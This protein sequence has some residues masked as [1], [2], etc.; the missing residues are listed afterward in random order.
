MYGSL[1]GRFWDVGLGKNL[2]PCQVGAKGP[3]SKFAKTA[4]VFN[5][6]KQ[7]KKRLKWEGVLNH[8]KTTF[9]KPKKSKLYM[10]NTDETKWG[11]R[12]EEKKL[13]KH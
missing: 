7:K 13:F 10:Q 8:L 5:K 2:M 1:F 9:L 4:Q 3:F 6:Q 11:S 12:R